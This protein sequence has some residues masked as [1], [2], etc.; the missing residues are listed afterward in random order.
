M[1]NVNPETASVDII[2][3]VKTMRESKMAIAKQFGMN[4]ALHD[5]WEYK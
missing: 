3:R 4:D 2:L 1:N 5:Y